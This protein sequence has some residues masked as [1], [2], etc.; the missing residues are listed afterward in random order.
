MLGVYWSLSELNRA[1][2]AA[3]RR[4]VGVVPA[5]ALVRESCQAT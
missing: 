5:A 1:L 3:A 4:F 2:T